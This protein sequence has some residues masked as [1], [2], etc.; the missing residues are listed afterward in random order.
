[1]GIVNTATATPLPGSLV[2]M[3]TGLVGLIGF[4]RKWAIPS[5]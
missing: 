3:F 1:V 4:G 2:L 5:A